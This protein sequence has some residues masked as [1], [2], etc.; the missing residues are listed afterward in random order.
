MNTSAIIPHTHRVVLCL[1]LLAPGTRAIGCASHRRA[2]PD[3]AEVIDLTTRIDAT[4]YACTVVINPSATRGG[5][6]LL[7]LHGSGECGDDN[8][9]QRT[10][11]LPVHAAQN[12]DAWPFVLVLPQKPTVF[13]EWED[14]ERAVL[15]MLD[16]AAERGLIDPRRLGITGLSQGGHGVI[17]LASRHPG[18]FR[19]AAPVCGYTRRRVDDDGAG[20]IEP[21]AVDAQTPRIVDAARAMSAMPVWIHHGDQDGVVPVEESRA[22]SDALRRIGADVRYSEYAGV[23]HNAWDNAYGDDALGAWF[24]EHLKR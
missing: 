21:G 23:G 6:A 2:A 4:T 13:S 12:P 22:L 18:R 15:A 17:T 1:V 19:A 5:A 9:K 10:V 16:A 20:W 11:G 7:F 3:P 14:H 24:A 8:L